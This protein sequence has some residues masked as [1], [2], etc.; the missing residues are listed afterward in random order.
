MSALP[1]GRFRI[2]RKRDPDDRD[3]PE[4]VREDREQP[5]GEEVEVV[6]RERDAVRRRTPPCSGIASEMPTARPV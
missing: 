3:R 4:R 2:E 6:L 1:S 5:R